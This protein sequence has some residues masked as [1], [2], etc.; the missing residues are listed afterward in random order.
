MTAAARPGR[1]RLRA[2]VAAVLAAATA[3]S[4]ASCSDE[5][6][7]EDLG[8][9]TGYPAYVVSSPLET[10]NAA[11]LTGAST[12]AAL[13]SGRVYPAVYTPGPNGQMI[14]NTDLASAQLL[15]GAK[16]KVLY[17]IAPEAS[18]SDGHTVTCDDF[19]LAV[20]AGKLDR[21]FGAQ[22][23][24]TDQVESVQCRPGAKRFQLTLV[25]G[26]GT[27]WRQL[28]G[29]G[30]ILPAHAIAQRAGVTEQDLVPLLDAALPGAGGSAAGG[31]A[32]AAATEISDAA[33]PDALREVARVWR[34]GFRLSE[35]DE[36][37]QLGYG[38]YRVDSVGEHGEVRLVRN[39]HYN[40]APAEEP[41]LVVWPPSV[42]THALAAQAH[43]VAADITGTDGS[44]IDRD[45]PGNRYEIHPEV[46]YLTETLLLG[47]GGVFATPED[48]DAFNACVDQK[49][50][51]AES[52]RVSGVEVPAVAMHVL[53][54]TDPDAAHV[55]EVSDVYLGTDRALAGRLK[56]TTIRIGYMGPDPRKAA[57]VESIRRS[58]EPA[59]IT[60]EDV[61]ET[62]GQL[63][64]LVGVAPDGE[65][66]VDAV[67]K[68]VDPAAEYSALAPGQRGWRA[69]QAAEAG[70]WRR[71]RAIP[72]ASQP[73]VFATDR[74]MGN[75]NVYTGLAGIGWNMDRWRIG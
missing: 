52:S 3:L 50:V 59:G 27:R 44:F 10:T 15:P 68:A 4:L 36:G 12:N 23:P 75:V 57:M 46:G 38:P 49:D 19:Y 65:D 41:T 62:T 39:E 64:D 42:D 30:E 43:V 1:G 8:E 32:G 45:N 20:A 54:P 9:N 14:P 31:A 56:G 24:W 72:L 74:E 69:L 33:V 55:A 16:R 6:A 7:G 17:D 40:G 66:R 47:E 58:C 67:L 5:E 11:S 29:P 53:N 34:D 63:G 37:L 70:E 51:A 26:A 22:P 2:A 28:F 25:E 21:L 48:R 71:V 60:V 35:F 73:R 18:F 61:S 13:I